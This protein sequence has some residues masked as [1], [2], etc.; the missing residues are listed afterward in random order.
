MTERD[1]DHTQYVVIRIEGNISDSEK[2]KYK[3]INFDETT[4]LF[5]P[6]SELG[7]LV[8]DFKG[9]YE[10]ITFSWSIMHPV[11]KKLIVEDWDIVFENDEDFEKLEEIA[12]EFYDFD[13]RL[14][15]IEKYFEV[16]YYWPDGIPD[17]ILHTRLIITPKDSRTDFIFY[18]GET[19][20]LQN[21]STNDF[22]YLFK[23]IWEERKNTRINSDLSKQEV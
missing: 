11:L 19:V 23:L 2:E 9:K 5:I 12:E 21:N 22:C 14:R 18:Y 10:M 15:E 7:K 20:E 3:F 6:C 16:K 1:I 17:P 13:E 4:L 8:K